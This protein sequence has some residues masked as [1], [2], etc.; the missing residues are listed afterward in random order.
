MFINKDPNIKRPDNLGKDFITDCHYLA[1]LF[2]SSEVVT[3]FDIPDNKSD[4][5]KVCLFIRTLEDNQILQSKSG[6]TLISIDNQYKKDENMPKEITL[7]D[8]M[9][10][11]SRQILSSIFNHTDEE[12]FKYACPVPFML[13]HFPHEEFTI[14][15][16]QLVVSHKVLKNF[17][18]PDEWSYVP[19][20]ESNMPKEISCHIQY[21][22][23]ENTNV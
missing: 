18:Q 20:K 19:I 3:D 13:L 12:I 14:V 10:L 8:Y 23:E 1:S 15:V 4:V 7:N 16:V 11:S 2:N 22:K 21:T 17:T 6:E 9:A 5:G